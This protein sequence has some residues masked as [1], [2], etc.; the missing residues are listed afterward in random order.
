MRTMTWHKKVVRPLGLIEGISAILLCFVATPAKY[1]LG[2]EHG[3]TILGP[4]HGFLYITYCMVFL[5]GL[6]S[7][8]NFKGF[9]FGGMAAS[10]P[11][12][13]LYFDRLIDDERFAGKLPK[14]EES[15]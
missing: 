4:I 13:T 10:I 9:F 8:W 6:G 7:V 3:V 1:L 2:Y 14:E 12:G 5:L 11:G 15:S